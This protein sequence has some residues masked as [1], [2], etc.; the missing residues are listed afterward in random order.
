MK[1]RQ[2]ELGGKKIKAGSTRRQHFRAE[3]DRDHNLGDPS[4]PRLLRKLALC[5]WVN[6]PLRGPDSLSGKEERYQHNLLYCASQILFFLQTEGLWEPCVEQVYP[7][8]SSNRLG[9]WVSF[10]SNQVFLIMSIVYLDIMLL[11]T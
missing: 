4:Q 8:H 1:L 5:L 10:F 6:Q 9:L 7:C 11:H 3:D 2:R